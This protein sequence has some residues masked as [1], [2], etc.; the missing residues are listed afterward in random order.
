MAQQNSMR[1]EIPA[2]I[3]QSPQFAAARSITQ[4]GLPA[5]F[6]QVLQDAITFGALELLNSSTNEQNMGKPLNSDSLKT[7]NRKGLMAMANSIGPGIQQQGSQMAMAQQSGGLQS[8]PTPNM[9]QQFASGGI[10]GFAKG[11]RRE[12]RVKTKAYRP[13]SAIP[14][15]NSNQP[16]PMLMQKYGG[17]KVLGYLAEKKA[18]D[19]KARALAEAGSAAGSMQIEDHKLM[20]E[21]FSEKYRDILNE[22]MGMAGGG[23]VGFQDGGRIKRF[24]GLEGSEVEGSGGRIKRFEERAVIADEQVRAYLSSLGRDIADFTAQQ[25]A[26]VKEIMGN[27]NLGASSEA[28]A[29]RAAQ[30]ANVANMPLDM[31]NSPVARSQND[32]MSQVGRG[33][34]GV[35]ADAVPDTA[36]SQGQIDARE[37][38]L[39]SGRGGIGAVLSR[40]NSGPSVTDQLLAAERRRAEANLTDEERAQRDKYNPVAHQQLLREQDMGRPDP[41]YFPQEAPVPPK[42]GGGI[43]NALR[44]TYGSLGRDMNPPA[45]P[46]VSKFQQELIDAGN[47]NVN[48]Q[49]LAADQRGGG[50]ASNLSPSMFERVLPGLSGLYTDEMRAAD[51]AAENTTLAEGMGQLREDVGGVMPNFGNIM[52]GVSKNVGDF[53]NESGL[54]GLDYEGFAR[55]VLPR[56]AEVSVN[57]PD[58]SLGRYFGAFANDL[59]TGPGRLTDKILNA[60]F[61]DDLQEGYYGEEPGTRSTNEAE[62]VANIVN[63]APPVQTSATY[64]PMK[65][66]NAVAN[67]NLRKAIEGTQAAPVSETVEEVVVEGVNSGSIGSGGFQ[68]R[69]DAVIA[70]QDDPLEAI[71]T[72]LRAMGEGDTIGEGL[73]IAGKALDARRRSNDAEQVALLKLLEAGSINERDYKLKQEQLKLE[74]QN[75]ENQR[76]RYEAQAANEKERTRITEVYYTALSGNNKQAAD[77]ALGEL[78]ASYLSGIAIESDM[79]GALGYSQKQLD[80]LRKNNY[81]AFETARTAALN[82]YMQAVTGAAPAA[83]SGLD[84]ATQAAFAQYQ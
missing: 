41:N 22:S 23:I 65:D 56:A 84:P 71:S 75:V 40:G 26:A 79:M 24:Q 82:K 52:Q 51:E 17:E 77:E 27:T 62:T 68:A 29:A 39:E 7:D 70:R 32:I 63:D 69:L 18:L 42:E 80:R 10:I 59:V 48:D 83:T 81:P 78:R 11:G 19:A 64:D 60:E 35:M 54:A 4:E 55:G 25:I 6:Q 15:G 46:A 13:Q 14:V 38:Q 50:I 28:R 37:A 73:Q 53:V 58:P 67:P 3:A 21:I 16:I 44:N 66:V 1:P 74:R 45:V 36:M 5:M 31:L 33:A 43:M 30:I 20:K 76:E 2:G 12:D 9:A 47:A 72:F 34:M 8:Q 57:S 49:L 61:I